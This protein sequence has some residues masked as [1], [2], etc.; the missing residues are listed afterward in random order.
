[1][2]QQNGPPNRLL[3]AGTVSFYLVAALAMVMANKWVLRSTDF[4]I[5]FLFIQMLIAVILF[6]VC[7]VVGIIQISM[8]FDRATLTGL[9]PLIF[10][11][12][13]GLTANNFTL[14]YVDASFYQ[15]VRG[16]L[17]PFTVFTSYIFL[18]SRPS[19]RIL[20]AC[21]IVT[22]GFFIG[23]F[24]D[25]TVISTRGVIYGVVSSM[26]SALHAVTMKR[27]LEVV[28]GSA[29]NLSWYTNLLSAIVLIPLIVFAGEIPAIMLVLHFASENLGTFIWG[30]AI[31]GGL[32]FLMS[33]AS[34]LSIKVTSPI[35][36]MISS[37]IRGI[38]V[39]FLGN[40]LF[41]EYISYGRM[42]AIA[43]ILAGSLYYTWVKHEES[44]QA[45]KNKYERVN[46]EDVEEGSATS[47][48]HAEGYR[49]SVA[50]Q[51]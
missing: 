6:L 50:E 31:T 40:K 2:S 11:N 30:S 23:I 12:V 25:G 27:S 46:L 41:G 35:T 19:L 22:A 21:A 42:W 26:M 51:K 48:K 29:L 39:S 24:L 8:R 1:M 5:F 20:Y 44:E 7:H 36:H 33:I 34:V 17:L 47:S 43:I 49:R 16:L 32:G 45:S 18:N 38:A 3:V 9:A 15:V 14:K 10:L 37:A 4:P 28:G 13:V